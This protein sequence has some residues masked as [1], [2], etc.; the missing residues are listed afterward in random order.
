MKPNITK[1]YKIRLKTG[2]KVIVLSGKY[3]GQ[4]GKVVKTHPKLNKVT[5]E[6]INIVKI[7]RKPTRENS[8]GRIE[9]VTKPIWVSKVSIME[10][11]LKKASK[12][13]Y[14]LTKDGAKKRVY[15]KSGKEIA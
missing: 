12:I 15:K 1:L 13:G 4:T 8:V 9:E 6:G 7:H 3:K 5:V 10:P 2:D 11:T 14:K